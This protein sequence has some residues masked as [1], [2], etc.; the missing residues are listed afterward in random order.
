M[1]KFTKV[2][3]QVVKP[4]KSK[5]KKIVRSSIFKKPNTVTLMASTMGSGKTTLLKHILKDHI[6]HYGLQEIPKDVE[7]ETSI[8]ILGLADA[9]PDKPRFERKLTILIFS[10]TVHNDDIYDDIVEMLIKKWL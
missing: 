5:K 1:I 10:G 4:V 8:N 9:D 2:N 3:D 7:P 6:L